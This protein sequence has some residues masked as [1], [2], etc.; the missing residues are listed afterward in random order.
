MYS[1]KTMLVLLAIELGVYAVGIAFWCWHDER[2]ARRIDLLM[3]RILPKV[4][5][6]F[7]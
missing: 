6:W 7:Y 4:R 2:R 3:A 5:D 1:M